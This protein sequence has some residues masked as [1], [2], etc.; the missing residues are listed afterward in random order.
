MVVWWCMD[1]DRCPP[2]ME[3]VNQDPGGRALYPVR[4]C[5]RSVRCVCAGSN[6]SSSSNG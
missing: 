4:W 5:T 3:G 1:L 2:D 6:F